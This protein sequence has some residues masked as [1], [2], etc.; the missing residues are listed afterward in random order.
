MPYKLKKVR[1]KPLYYVINSINGH[2]HSK[3]PLTKELALKQ[4]RAIYAS[5]SED[6]EGAGIGDF[7]KKGYNA[8]KSR[9]RAFQGVRLDYSPSIREFLQS[10][11]ESIISGLIV[12]RAPVDAYVK[13]LANIVS[14][15]KF[16]QLL[17][18]SYDEVYH[19]FMKIDLK[20]RKVITLN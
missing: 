3:E 18:K 2:R 10:N 15:G 19:L 12:Y 13:T 1:N 20:W 4:L 17:D 5:N 16:K 8:I 6:I 9:L 11:S 7:F 14:L